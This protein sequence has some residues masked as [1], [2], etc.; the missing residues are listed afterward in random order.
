ME[1]REELAKTLTDCLKQKKVI[2]FH[3]LYDE[4]KKLAEKNVEDVS[5][6]REVANKEDNKEKR[7]KIKINFKPYIPKIKKGNRRKQESEFKFSKGLFPAA[8][9]DAKAFLKV[10]DISLLKE[11]PKP[12]NAFDKEIIYLDNEDAGSKIQ[13]DHIG[14]ALNYSITIS[15]N[16]W[17]NN[18]DNEPLDLSRKHQSPQI[19]QM[20]PEEMPL[21]LSKTREDPYLVRV[22]EPPL[23]PTQKTFVQLIP[24]S[25]H[26]GNHCFPHEICKLVEPVSQIVQLS[27]NSTSPPVINLQPIQLV[28]TQRQLI[29]PETSMGKAVT[30]LETQPAMETCKP[31][32]VIENSENNLGKVSRRKKP[33]SGMHPQDVSQNLQK[34]NGLPFRKQETIER[35]TM[36]KSLGI[37][38]HEG[39]DAEM[40]NVVASPPNSQTPECQLAPTTGIPRITKQ[41][42]TKSG[43]SSKNKQNKEAPIKK[44]NHNQTSMVKINEK[45]TSNGGVFCT[46]RNFTNQGRSVK[47]GKTKAQDKTKKKN[48]K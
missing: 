48:P 16:S 31:D 38:I 10:K 14:E 39:M 9:D 1:K 20:Q 22:G 29:H 11:P 32:L 12:K 25:S 36:R 35:N 34:Y 18:N 4:S 23:D 37:Q 19:H 43:C 26:G 3:N 5:D 28:Y 27:S 40:L 7:M 46:F 2:E 47:A 6:D 42:R 33:K 45:V 41:P 8:K 24:I 13:E 21:D 30:V 44:Q 15:D 17:V